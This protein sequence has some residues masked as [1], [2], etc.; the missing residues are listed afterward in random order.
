M[1]RFWSKVR[2]TD[3]CWEWRASTNR[4]GYGTFG[5][6]CK[7][8]K[9]HRVSWVLAYGE[10][11]EDYCVCHYCDNPSC[12]CPDHLFLGTN[13]D[14]S[15][16]K[17]AKDRHAKG[18]TLAKGKRGELNPQSVLTETDI[19][20][21]RRDFAPRCRHRGTRALGRKYGVSHQ[22]ISDILNGKRWQHV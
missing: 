13:A 5:F 20:E 21:I 6:R 4:E 17:V 22:L 15:Q 2:K 3:N 18:E 8:W 10:I 14:N 7:V 1:Q 12:V 16:D 19:I 9:A 11:P